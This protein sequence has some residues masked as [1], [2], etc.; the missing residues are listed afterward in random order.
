LTVETLNDCP[1]D[2]AIGGLR[3][4]LAGQADIVPHFSR[5][6]CEH[7]HSLVSFDP[8]ERTAKEPG[9][10]VNDA[11]LSRRRPAELSDISTCETEL[12]A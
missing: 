9:H 8:K 2:L 1:P 7:G 3:V 11:V 5:P 12:A 6:R 10:S 4:E